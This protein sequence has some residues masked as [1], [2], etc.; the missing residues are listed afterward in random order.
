LHDFF[1][2]QGVNLVVKQFDFKF[3]LHVY[4][5]VVF[6]VSAVNLGL[7][8][9]AHHDDGRSVGGLERKYQIQQNERIW[10]PMLDVRHHA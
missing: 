2:S 8:V 4:P 5:I 10:V 9:L 6:C 1:F 3:R 7:T